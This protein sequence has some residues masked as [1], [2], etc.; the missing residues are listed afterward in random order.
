MQKGKTL[1]KVLLLFAFVLA[2]TDYSLIRFWL[3]RSP[4]P[5]PFPIRP[6]EKYKY[7]EIINQSNGE[8][9]TYVTVPVGV[10]DEYITGDNCRYVV[11]RMSGNKAYAKYMGLVP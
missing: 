3:P 2:I 10:G 9:L 4:S 6:H 1:K 8:T 7:Y 11:V 5:Q